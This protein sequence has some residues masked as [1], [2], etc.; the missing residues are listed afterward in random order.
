MFVND[1]MFLLIFLIVIIMEDFLIMMEKL[2]TYY[3]VRDVHDVGVTFRV[4]KG[5]IKMN[6]SYQCCYWYFFGYFYV[7]IL[8]LL[9][10]LFVSDF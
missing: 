3:Y 2:M 9:E 10:D 7:L 8:E 1:L 6:I 5:I 4:E